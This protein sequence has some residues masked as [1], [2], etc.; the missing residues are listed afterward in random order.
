MDRPGL[1]V[2]ADR[3][4]GVGEVG[5]VALDVGVDEVLP[6]DVE[7]LHRVTEVVD[8]AGEIEAPERLELR[9]RREP[10]VLHRQRSA[11]RL[12]ER[13]QRPVVAA[14]HDQRPRGD[15]P[16]RGHD[17]ERVLPPR[18]A[19]VDPE[20]LVDGHDRLEPALYTVDSPLGDAGSGWT[21]S[22]YVS[23]TSTK[24]AVAPYAMS[25]FWPRITYG[26]PGGCRPER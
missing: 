14:R 12:V 17:V 19:R 2:L 6:A 22:M 4:L 7:V 26:V 16:A 24:C 23:V 15:R 8:V 13:Q 18:R 5:D 25:R 20:R 21:F 9:G 10:G 3:H 1:Q 11:R